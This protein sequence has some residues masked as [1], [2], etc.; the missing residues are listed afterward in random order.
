MA[1]KSSVGNA[2]IQAALKAGQALCDPSGTGKHVIRGKTVFQQGPGNNQNPT[3]STTQFATRDVQ[4]KGDILCVLASI[5]DMIGVPNAGFLANPNPGQL[6]INYKALATTTDYDTNNLI[7][8]ILNNYGLVVQ[9]IYTLSDIFQYMLKYDG[10]IILY[11]EGGENSIPP[12]IIGPPGGHFVYIHTYDP[13]TDLYFIGQSFGNQGALL[14]HTRGYKITDLVKQTP[15]EGGVI[16]AF[17]VIANQSRRIAA[18]SGVAVLTTIVAGKSKITTGPINPNAFGWLGT[19]TNSRDRDARTGK[20]T[21]LTAGGVVRYTFF[22]KA[23]ETIA[24]TTWGDA[25]NDNLN[26]LD[27]TRAAWETAGVTKEGYGILKN[28]NWENENGKDRLNGVAPR[29]SNILFIQL[30]ANAFGYE[31][32][33]DTVSIEAS[34]IPYVTDANGNTVVPVA[35]DRY[36]VNSPSPEGYALYVNLTQVQSANNISGATRYIRLD[37]NYVPYIAIPNPAYTGPGS[38]VP[39]LMTQIAPGNHTIYKYHKTN[40][41]IANISIP[42]AAVAV[43]Q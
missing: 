40:P 21:D 28:V 10:Y 9:P 41:L 33:E 4:F 34:R 11:G 27:T 12:F 39:Y 35:A 43:G 16:T 18:G 7:K 6:A 42:G 31:G 17:G 2:Q 26:V 25:A 22:D 38:S 30:V 13:V 8:T 23:V 36:V 24:D 5:I 1:K 29:H 3:W 37:G 14:D 20:V 32:D 15:A 19:G